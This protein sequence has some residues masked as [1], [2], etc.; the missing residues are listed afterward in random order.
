MHPCFLLL[1]CVV[2]VAVVVVVKPYQVCCNDVKR[3]RGGVVLSACNSYKARDRHVLQ[4]HPNRKSHMG[5]P[6]D[7]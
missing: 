1:F 4:L 7:I 3:W 5:S 2:D 6:K